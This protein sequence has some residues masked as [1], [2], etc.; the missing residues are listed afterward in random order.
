MAIISLQ[1]AASGLSALN[2]SMDVIANNLANVNTAGF[3]SSR[4]NFQ[5]LLYIH[6]ALPGLENAEGDQRPIG[7]HV[8]LGVKVAGTQLDF[9]PGSPITT[10]KPTDVAIEG[11]GFFQVRVGEAV[12][13]D[14]FAYT[15]AGQFTLNADG[16]LVLASDPG[17]RLEPGITIPADAK[18][19]AISRSGEV[20]YES[21]GDTERQV[22]GQIE[23]AVFVNPTGLKPVGENLYARSE[24]SGP[25]ITGNPGEDNRGQL[26]SGVYEGSNVDPTRE[27][28]DLIRTQR[29]FEMNS[30]TIRAADD[31]LRTIAQLRR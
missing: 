25:A 8:G 22:A 27:L 17:R 4:A 1:S 9:T 19:I 18:D 2:T 6:R 15:R 5:D 12:S 31:A 30:Q 11:L 24:A 21:P 23:T 7:L 20:T 16:E 13:P 14:G 28:I 3:K 10:D 26:L 29:A